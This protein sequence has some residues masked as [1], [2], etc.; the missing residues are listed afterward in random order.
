LEY[1]TD[2]DYAIA[3]KNGISQKRAHQRF[4]QYGWDR[5][6]AFTQSIDKVTRWDRYKS[7]CE[8]N[9]ISQNTFDR[10][11]KRG[12][13]PDEAATTKLSSRGRKKVSNS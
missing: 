12:K 5:E 6:R 11:I 4:Y 10:R 1:L 8:A 9:G 13:S 3:A 2:E 7:I